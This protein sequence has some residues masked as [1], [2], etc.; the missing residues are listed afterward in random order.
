MS[1]FAKAL[2]APKEKTANTRHISLL[3]AAILVV[4][5]VAQ[6]FTFDEFTALILSFNLPFSDKGVLVIAPLLVMAELF[7]LPFLLR[8]KL[9]FAFR[10]LSMLF[11]WLVPVLWLFISSWV[12]ST[13]PGAETVG[14]LGTVV[15]V[16]PGWWAIFVSI[17]LGILA[18]WASWGMWPGRYVRNKK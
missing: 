16:I 4:F 13:Q 3:Y 1:I 18:S 2:P 14:F 17:A 7:A 10:W 12:V 15:S 8:M 11:G 6:L 9:S 5:L